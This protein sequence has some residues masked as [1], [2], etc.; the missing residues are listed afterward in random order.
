M[1]HYSNISPAVQKVGEVIFY[2]AD[3]P[4]VACFYVSE[5]Q[6]LEFLNSYKTG[7]AYWTV[8]PYSGKGAPYFINSTR[9]LFANS[10]KEAAK[11]QGLDYT[12]FKRSAAKEWKDVH[13]IEQ[14]NMIAA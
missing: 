9:K 2:Y 5:S 4:P 8:I 1:T 12:A 14:L 7:T 13:D 3:K 10:L 11:L 6:R